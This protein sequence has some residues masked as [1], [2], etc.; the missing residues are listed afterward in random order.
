MVTIF[1]LENGFPIPALVL[2]DSP[3]DPRQGAEC[4]CLEKAI[5]QGR[6]LYTL[7]GGQNVCYC[8]HTGIQI[9]DVSFF[10]GA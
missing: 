10:P 2:E 6:H 3:N 7:E 5:Y 4:I 1:F 8:I 9:I